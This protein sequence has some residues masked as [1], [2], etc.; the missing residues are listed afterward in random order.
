M[1]GRAR[2]HLVS[3]VYVVFSYI[4][5]VQAGD[6]VHRVYGRTHDDD[7]DDENYTARHRLILV[8]NDMVPRVHSTTP[9]NSV[10]GVVVSTILCSGVRYH[11][12]RVPH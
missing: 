4:S 3:S 1:A 6:L 5:V 2:V 10:Q 8:Y 12:T 7:D 9:P 11:A